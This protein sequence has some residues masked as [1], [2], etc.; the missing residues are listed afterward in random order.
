MAK[1]FENN[2]HNFEPLNE[3]NEG[4]KDYGRD[5]TEQ[6]QKV[7][8]ILENMPDELDD[9]IMRAIEHARNAA[10]GEVSQHIEDVSHSYIE[11]VD[12]IPNGT[13]IEDNTSRKP[14]Q[15]KDLDDLI[16]LL[17][18][19]GLNSV[20]IAQYLTSKSAENTGIPNSLHTYST[21]LPSSQGKND[22]ELVQ[23]V[24]GSFEGMPDELDDD[25]MF[26]IEYARNAA[27]GVYSQH[28]RDITNSNLKQVDNISTLEANSN[29]SSQHNDVSAELV[30]NFYN[31]GLC[32]AD[33]SLNR[34]DSK[35]IMRLRGEA[36]DPCRVLTLYEL[37]IDERRTLFDIVIQRETQ[38]T[39][40]QNHI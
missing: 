31:M 14:A 9:D 5:N 10:K 27:N 25:I 20:Q 15:H 29:F 36:L 23:E 33:G 7:I 37:T 35:E 2:K 24:M 40:G 30:R 6:I 19:Q 26:A 18:A 39:N 21:S 28:M 16:A 32:D 34:A 1:N 3:T 12:N 17:K 38:N 4:K 8:D 13:I 11:R 22:A